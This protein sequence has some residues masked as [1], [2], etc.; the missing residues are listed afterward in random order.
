MLLA[1]P[2]VISAQDNTWE[3]VPQN[4]L[5]QKYMVGAVPEVDG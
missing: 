2:L 3:Q 1:M 5:D 4:N